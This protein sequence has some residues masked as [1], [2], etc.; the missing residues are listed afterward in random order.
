MEMTSLTVSMAAHPAALPI[1][2]YI[3]EIQMGAP[4]L[5]PMDHFVTTTEVVL[6]QPE[7]LTLYLGHATFCPVNSLFIATVI[8]DLLKLDIIK[9]MLTSKTLS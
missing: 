3:A 1:A 8:L 4:H 9:Q 7:K 2:S 5:T 6:I